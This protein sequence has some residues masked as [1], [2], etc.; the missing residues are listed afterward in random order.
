MTTNSQ[1]AWVQRNRSRRQKE[2]AVA[3]VLSTYVNRLFPDEGSA[4]AEACR[5]VAAVVD[6]TFN[7]HCHLAGLQSRTL[8][9]EVDKPG[10][11]YSMRVRWTEAIS[12]ALSRALGGPT[13][14]RVLFRFGQ[15]REQRHEKR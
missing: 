6:D 4:I 5:A 8:I 10:L 7:S 13:T 14:G 3:E 2:R 9:V 11:I 12:E 1:L 15:P